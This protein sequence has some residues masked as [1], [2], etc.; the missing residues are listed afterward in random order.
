[1]FEVETNYK[2]LVSKALSGILLAAELSKLVESL[3]AE[4]ELA[5]EWG[6]TPDKFPALV[7][8]CPELALALLAAVDPSPKKM[9]YYQAL[10]KLPLNTELASFIAR[11][12]DSLE[13]PVL[14]YE[15]FVNLGIENCMK[16][17]DNEKEDVKKKLGQARMLARIV[18][19]Q[20]A[21]D[22]GF[23]SLI[24]PETLDKVLRVFEGK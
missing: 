2:G 8:S 16:E 18:G 19:K 14:F 10:L 24:Q 23:V 1:M 6:L 3:K 20:I 17:K 13:V 22:P 15:A 11:L 7:Q 21:K 12:Q 9:D 5:S 4:P